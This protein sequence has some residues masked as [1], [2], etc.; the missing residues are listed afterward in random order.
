MGRLI[1]FNSIFLLDMWLLVWGG[2]QLQQ[3]HQDSRKGHVELLHG[4]R[5]RLLDIG[6]EVRANQDL[7]CHYDEVVEIWCFTIFDIKPLALELVLYHT[8]F[9]GPI[10]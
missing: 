6:K 9:E 8:E 10:F 7:S 2:G 1:T 5:D 3:G 4:S